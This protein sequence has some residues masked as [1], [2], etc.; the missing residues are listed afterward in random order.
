VINSDTEKGAEVSKTDMVNKEGAS[1]S[2]TSCQR[3]LS[4]NSL[5]NKC[6]CKL[7]E[8]EGEYRY[9]TVLKLG[10]LLPGS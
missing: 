6:R 3:S 1:S 5:E 7:R 9:A 2:A 10:R 4:Q 8:P